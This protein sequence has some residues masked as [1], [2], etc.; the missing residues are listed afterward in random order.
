MSAMYGM[1]QRWI[2]SLKRGRQFVAHDIWHIGLP[3][4]RIPHGLI[5]KQIRVA[6]LLVRGVTEETLL[7]RASALTF[8]TMLFI[9]PFLAL[10]FY[11]IQAFNLGDQVYNVMSERV[12]Q[13]LAHIISL[14]KGAEEPI[15][16]AD[17]G[18]T[19]PAAPEDLE[20]GADSLAPDVAI[21][22]ED[23]APLPPQA[24]EVSP[25]APPDHVVSENNER[26]QMEIMA[27]IFPIFSPEAGLVDAKAGENPI[28]ILANLAEQGATNPQAVGI[29]GVL[30]V[31]STVLGFMRN[32]ESSF[33][34]IWGVRRKRNLFRAISDYMMVTLLLP[35]VAAGVLGVSAILE[36]QHVLSLLGPLA[37]GLRGGQF[38][39][40]WLTFTLLYY[41]VPNTRVEFRYAL[42]GGLVAG[43]LWVLCSWGYIRF[44]FG[45]ARY[46]LFFSTFSLFPMLLMWIYLS[47]L[48]LLL[49]ALLTYAYQNEKT[50]AIERLAAGA[51]HAYR[52]ALAVR[53]IIEMAGRF[54]R[55]APALSV[56]EA[57]ESWNVPTR[58][59]SDT[60]DCLVQRN[61]VAE[62]ATEPVSYQ[63]AR[64]PETIR[65]IDV[66]RAVKETGRDPSRLRQ[67]E[68]YKPLYEGLDM[69]DPA[70]FS[71][72][73][74]ELADRLAQ[75]SG[76][77]AQPA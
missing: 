2:E 1:I 9:V 70:C 37:I 32:V 22:G 15:P 11:L 10:M 48:I 31:L 75:S 34:G 23:N 43:V 40:I 36:S 55:G 38:A 6:I 69:G 46:N 16:P 60:L 28:K 57:A 47:W 67:D 30:F 76:E 72:T 5:I 14:V 25:E 44:Q 66:L 12:D 4:E 13:H 61:L 21:P 52:E 18:E 74:A 17:T 26:L 53:A 7:L 29:A 77:S 62:C 59:L 63:P 50:F 8:A 65:L 42:L 49:G 33:N 27:A 54:R 35:F 73:A 24:A 45:L 51:S 58:L 64:A 71:A 68:K 41:F 19:P 20:E 3:G 56:V 39:V